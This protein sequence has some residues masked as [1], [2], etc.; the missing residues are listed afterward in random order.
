M[1][2]ALYS[3]YVWSNTIA[4]AVRGDPPASDEWYVWRRSISSDT[5]FTNMDL[6]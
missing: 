3:I 1:P 2:Q 6:L 4:M 5:H